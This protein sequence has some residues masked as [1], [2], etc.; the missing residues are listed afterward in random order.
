[1][2]YVSRLLTLA[3][4][5]DP[6]GAASRIVALEKMLAERQWDRTRNRDRNATYNKTSLGSLQ[7]AMPQFDWG[8]YFELAAPAAA[9]SIT[10]VIV[11]Q[12]DYLRA[13]DAALTAVPLQT[14]KDYLTFGTIAAFADYLPASFVDAQ[15]QFNGKVIG[16]RT[17]NQPRWKRGVSTTEGALGDAVGRLY[18][19]RYFKDDAKARIDALIRNLLAAFKA[20]IDELEWMSPETR[21][22]A[23]AKLAKYL[24]EDRVSRPVARLLGARGQP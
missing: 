1:M 16:G 14:W 17:E 7:E 9:A 4:Q 5:P 12:P 8:Q 23:Q 18:V 10:S 20:G 13:V 22:Q 3:A 15:F 11:R 2:D 6:A 24:A 21:V 19:E